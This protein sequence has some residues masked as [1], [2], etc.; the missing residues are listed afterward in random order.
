MDPSNDNFKFFN[1]LSLNTEDNLLKR[2]R[3]Y[4]GSQ[5]N[6]PLNN[7][8]TNE[9]VR[10]N[11]FPDTEDLNNNKSLDQTEAFYEYKIKVKNKGGEM[12]VENLPFYRETTIITRSNGPDEKWYRFQI[13]INAGVPINGIAGF[14]SIQFMRLYM[15]NFSTPKTFRLADFQ[16]LRNQWR[17]QLPKCTT[18]AG[19]TITFNVDDVGIEEN[20]GK[21]PFNYISPKGVVR[22]QSFGTF[23]NLLQD[24]KSMVLKFQDLQRGCEVSVTKL[25]RLNLA[26]YKRM[27]LFV[28]AEK[29]LASAQRINDGKI[30]IFVR[31][32]KDFVNNYYE[33]ELPLTISKDT[34]SSPQNASNIWPESNYINFPL[35]S[36]L[37]LKRSRLTNNT[38]TSDLIEMI[39][40]P[41]KGDKVKMKG[42]PSLGLVKVF[43]IGVR[44]IDT[45][46]VL[47]DGEVW[48]NE[49]RVTGFEESG[50]VAALA[51]VQIQMADLGELNLSTN[52]SSIGFGA[53]DK[54]LLERN[55]EETFQYDIAAN[56]DAGKILP[57]QLKLSVPVY[58]QYSK[59]LITPQFDPF[60]QDLKV[61][62]KLALIQ[63]PLVRDTIKERSREEITIKTFNLTNVK[64]QAGGTGKPWSP[65][66]LSASYAYT[67][68]VKQDPIISEDVFNQQSLG[69][70]Y[71]YSRK[72]SYIEPLKFI[73]SNSLKILSEFNFSL[74]PSNFSFTSR[75]INVHNSRTFR[76]PIT[77]VFKFDDLRFNWERNYVL[78]WDLT[79]SIRFNFRANSNSIIDQIRQSGIAETAEGRDYF[80]E[81]GYNVTQ[82]VIDDPSFVSQYRNS[83]IKN[84]GRSKNYN[85]NISVNYRLPFKSVPI[86]DWITASADYKST[87]AWDGGSLITIDNRVQADGSVGTPL[88]NTIR[89]GQNTGVNFTF[90]FDKLYNKSNYLKSIETGKAPRTSRTRRAPDRT[91]G[92]E[93]IKGKEE[94]PLTEDEDKKAKEKEKKKKDDTPRDP[95]LVERIL[96]RPLMMMRSVKFNYRD[97]RATVI[98][99]FMPQSKLLGLS[100]GFSSPGWDFISGF[101]PRISGENN[102]LQTNQSWFNDSPAFNDALSQTKR[103][104][105]D[106]RVLVE[107]FKDFSVDVTFKKNYTENHTEVFRQKN[108]PVTGLQFLQLAKYD[109]GS[110]D[111][112]YFALNTLF[113]NRLSLYENFKDNRE[114][115]SRRLPNIE[116]PGVHPS[117]PSFV[118]GYG[119]SQNSVNVAAFIS[120]YTNQ[121]PFDIELEQQKTFAKNNYIPAPNWQVNYNG[122]SRMKG[123]KDIFSNITIKHG[124]TSSIRVNN[125]Q[126]AANYN[127]N[128][129]FAELSPNNNYYSRIEIPTVSISEQFVPIIGISVKTVKDMKL[130]FEYRVTRSLEL[131]IS[132]LREANSKEITVGGGYVIKNFK[133]F[134]SKKK[135]KKKKD[136]AEPED[137]NAQPSA[138]AGNNRTS[139]A[140]GRDLRINLSYSLKD[141][142]SEVYNLLTGIAAQADRGSKTVTF[143]PTVEYDVNKNL[144]LRFYFDYS[145]ITPRTSLSFPI[146][147][148]RSGIT[149]RF[150]I[151]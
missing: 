27:Q 80:D 61:K 123:L 107:P 10:G 64:T 16:I 122:L 31:V 144:A 120:A 43:Q 24:E 54:R 32:G 67:E 18:D 17:K 82:S 35:D 45:D 143:S 140:K 73:K 33:Y 149:L 125:F 59:T 36:L 14:R 3:M 2:L 53:L 77:P 13:P 39:V 60:D 133:A 34:I 110:F 50:G 26:L 62:E 113:S 85:H 51:K 108:M 86:L 138:R 44:N 58:A 119:P 52:Y 100:E 70:D 7:S 90:S 71:V 72:S 66:N 151:N 124:Y 1:D 112:S 12:D 129:P 8:N 49:F 75:M 103:Q 65:S 95:S 30:A 92:L 99:G 56:I 29:A 101:Q 121:S 38:P 109:I 114:I 74:L 76:L 115:I 88:G 130:D 145:K 94:A 105:F 83:N 23:A 63:D 118:T 5:G 89:N 104:T 21:K 139:V 40:N 141:D 126:T 116:N 146:T 93:N 142:I 131:G 137:P 15:T 102:W 4:N 148:I 87:Y 47:Y 41:D 136:D 79:R 37:E 9:F 128:D 81:N 11:R 78:D 19:N 20:S 132:Q 28:H 134:G 96:I 147:T 106:L 22:I 42:N 135:T 55:R 111:A 25:A 6:A 117:D 91:R 57:Q 150:T 98:P 69:V 68:T 127:A 97:E 84:L 48:I 46:Q